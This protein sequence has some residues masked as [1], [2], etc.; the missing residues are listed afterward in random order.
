MGERLDVLKTYKLFIG[1][2]FPRSESGRSVVATGAR[3]QPVAHVSKASRKDLRDAVEAARAAQGK[4]AG[5][6]AYNR[7]QVVYRMAEMLEGKRGEFERALVARGRGKGRASGA[8]GEAEAA[9]DRLVHYAGWAD[10]YPQVLG[11]NNPVAGPHYNFTIPEPMGVVVVVPDDGAPLLSLVSLLAPAM[12]GGNACVVVAGEASPLAASMF[13][14]VC[15]TSDVPGGV[16]NIL[17]GD[18]AELLPHV[19]THR[20]VDA[21]HAGNVSAAEAGLLRGGAAEN[22]KRVVLQG[23]ERRVDWR[24]GKACESPWW[25]EGLV[26]M[27]TIWHPSAV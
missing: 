17:T 25:I 13:G 23:L 4:W 24:D 21:V 14:E 22:L 27:K 18:R 5:M 2:Q 20:E 19:A 6:T 12:V 3:G 11:C 8:T 1:G 9:V 26:E 16:V 15:A 7:G 10:K